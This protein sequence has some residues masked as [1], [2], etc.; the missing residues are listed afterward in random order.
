MLGL[1][2]DNPLWMRAHVGTR[3]R[4]KG[5]APLGRNYFLINWEIDKNVWAD[6]FLDIRLSPFLD[7]GRIT[8]PTPGLGSRRWLWDTG[9]QAKLRVLGVGFMFV[10]GKDL[11]SGKDAFYVT[12]VR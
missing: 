9:V 1:E 10:Y 8:D 5:N 11:R 7:T 12:G 2:R 4:R 3:H 6:R